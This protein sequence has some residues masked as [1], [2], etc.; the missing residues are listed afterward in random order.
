[1]RTK[2]M[3]RLSRPLS[4]LLALTITVSGLVLFSSFGAVHAAQSS[5]KDKYKDDAA[6]KKLEEDLANISKK[7]AGLKDD[8]AAL[9]DD[10]KDLTAK[11]RGYDKLIETCERKIEV[12]EQ[13]IAEMDVRAEALRAE[14]DEKTKKSEE[15]YAQIKERIVVSYEAGGSGATYLELIFGAEN[16]IDFLIGLDN[17]VS[18]MEY[19]M[20]LMQEYKDV[21]SEL[22]ASHEK[23][24]ADIAEK[25]SALDALEL[26]RAET[27]KLI[28]QCEN[29]ISSAMSDIES[30]TKVQQ[31]LA[32]DEDAAAQRIDEYIEWLESQYGSEMAPPADT[33]PE[34]T[35]PPVT[36][37]PAPETTAPPPPDTTAPPPD[38]DPP[39][40]DAPPTTDTPPVT[41]EPPVTDTPPVADPPVD[42][43]AVYLWPLPTQ[44][45]TI[46]SKFGPRYHP[47]TG[48]YSN[49]GGVDI[50]APR[51]TSIYASRSGT[52]V[53]AGEDDSYG[54]YIMIDHGGN[55]YTLYAH[56]NK[57]L[58]SAGTYVT[59]GTTIAEVGMT[60]SATG[61]HLHFEVR[62]GKTR[63]NPLEYVDIP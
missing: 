2:I 21:T 63:V 24:D 9:N 51:G 27:E 37:A 53:I 36:T 47:I 60:G 14:I 23:L 25:Q 49:H 19:D 31:K 29:L 43:D 5:D 59:K 54:N 18:I 46:T 4:A 56:C 39:V 50:A 58:V 7:Q 12:T 38:T 30:M 11:K 13:L 34:T 1:M 62:L 44:H 52:V 22:V 20:R 26:E 61:Y 10:V 55:V 57:L 16:V 42:D 8:I 6:I 32:S 40:T 41:D 48:V 45:K 17:A 28:L 35:T 3:K 15:L 33:T